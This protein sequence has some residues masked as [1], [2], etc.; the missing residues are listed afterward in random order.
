MIGLLRRDLFS[1]MLLSIKNG[2]RMIKDGAGLIWEKKS[3][4]NQT[5]HVG[6][7]NL[8]K[9]MVKGLRKGKMLEDK[10]AELA[11]ETDQDCRKKL[12]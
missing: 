11:K 1:G 2:Q 10:L 3:R 4:L 5:H 9:L 8:T 7:W 12:Y 6:L